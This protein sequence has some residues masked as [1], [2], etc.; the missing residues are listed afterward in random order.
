MLGMH[1]PKNIFHYCGSVDFVMY[2][3]FMYMS[4]MI[5]I[6]YYTYKLLFKIHLPGFFFG[7]KITIIKFQ[8]PPQ[9]P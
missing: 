5:E 8:R 4:E 1:L 9:K 2:W 7:K 6:N 3:A